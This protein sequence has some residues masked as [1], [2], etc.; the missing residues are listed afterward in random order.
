[1][2]PAPRA[3]WPKTPL[4]SVYC[5][6]GAQWH[7]KHTMSLVIADHQARSGDGRC[8]MLAHSLYKERFRCQ[9]PACARK[10]TRRAVKS[11]GVKR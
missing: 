7:G 6:C 8:H 1:M 9:C 4:P 2:I 5:A 11:Q 3:R 10:G